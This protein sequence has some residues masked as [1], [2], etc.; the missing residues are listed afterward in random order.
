MNDTGEFFFSVITICFNNYNGLKNTHESLC[1][2]DFQDYEWIVIDGASDDASA[3]YLDALSDS[4]YS[5]KSEKDFGIYDAMN[6]GLNKVSG[7]YVIFMNSGDEFNGSQVL[8][9][10]HREVLMANY[11]CF[12]YGDAL[13]YNHFGL[14]YKKAHTSDWLP[15]G[16]FAHHQSMVYRASVI[17]EQRYNLEFKIASDYAFTCQFLKKTVKIKYLPSAICKFEGGGLTSST[18]VHWKGV[19]EQW[20]IG[21]DILKRNVFQV[22]VTFIKQI[23]KHIII[24]LMPSLHKRLR[25]TEHHEAR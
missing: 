2:Q 3:A 24:R 12:I 20:R 6:K 1:N 19:V 21:R 9:L 22:S 14:V 23:L 13:E 7:K 17:G 16:M 5:I 25:Y 4:R 11:P 8:S 10:I 15:N 18:D